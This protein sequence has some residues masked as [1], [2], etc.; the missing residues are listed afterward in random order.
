[1][2]YNILRRSLGGSLLPLGVNADYTAD[3]SGQADEAVVKADPV[4]GGEGDGQVAD[5][6]DELETAGEAFPGEFHVLVNNL[7]KRHVVYICKVEETHFRMRLL[8]T[9]P[10]PSFRSILASRS[11]SLYSVYSCA[12]TL[13]TRPMAQKR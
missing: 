3:S 9:T 12:A 7:F 2:F 8:S 13:K 5:V 11:F 10:S 4:E 6:G 1:M